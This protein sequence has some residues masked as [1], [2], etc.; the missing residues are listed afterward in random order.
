MAEVIKRER[1]PKRSAAEV[2]A[3]MSENRKSIELF[4]AHGERVGESGVG[5]TLAAFLNALI[6]R[7]NELTDELVRSMAR[8]R[9]DDNEEND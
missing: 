2:M 6:G 8:A 4:V 9:N 5:T 7:G 1:K 3:A